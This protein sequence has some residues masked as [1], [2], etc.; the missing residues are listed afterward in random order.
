MTSAR[1]FRDPDLLMRYTEASPHMEALAMRTLA[2]GAD[3]A[4]MALPYDDRLVGDLESGV[5]HGGVVTTLIDSVSGLAVLGAM[6]ELG[7]LATLDL[8]IDYLKPATP[9]LELFARAHCVKITRRIAFTR[10]TAYH[11]RGDAEDAIAVSQATFII[12][13]TGTKKTEHGA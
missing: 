13:S 11:Q 1:F 9:G 8:R 6:A 10:A 4:A 12:K 7:P 2:V 5:L 3:G